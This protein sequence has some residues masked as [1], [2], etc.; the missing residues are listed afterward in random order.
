MNMWIDEALFLLPD[1]LRQLLF[2]IIPDLLKR[3]KVIYAFSVFK[4]FDLQRLCRTSCKLQI[5]PRHLWVDEAE[6]PAHVDFLVHLCDQVCLCLSVLV[7][8]SVHLLESW[9]RDLLDGAGYL[10]AWGKNAIFLH[11]RNLV[12]GAQKCQCIVRIITCSTCDQSLTDTISVDARLLYVKRRN[13]MLV[14]TVGHNDLAVCK[15]FIIE[16]F[17]TLMD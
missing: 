14:E 7:I 5:S 17:L 1:F 6:I 9:I 2:H 4:Y 16:H 11:C 15:P 12:H 8:D 10:D 3:R 13:R